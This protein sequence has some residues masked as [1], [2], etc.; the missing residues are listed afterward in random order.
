VDELKERMSK[1][2]YQINQ[3]DNSMT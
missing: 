3:I 2:Q 1:L